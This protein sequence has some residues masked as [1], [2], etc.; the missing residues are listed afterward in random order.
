[1]HIYVD[2]FSRISLSFAY[3]YKYL[4]NKI[5]LIDTHI[6]AHIINESMYIRFAPQ[7]WCRFVLI[8]IFITTT[9]NAS[10]ISSVSQYDGGGWCGA[11]G[12][13]RLKIIGTHSIIEDVDGTFLGNNIGGFVLART[14]NV[15]QPA[16]CND[17]KKNGDETSID[18]GSK[19]GCPKCANGMEC[20]SASDCLSNVC[21]NS[22]CLVGTC[23]KFFVIYA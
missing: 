14:N 13:C 2:N 4:C 19:A 22:K 6:K 17:G 10:T 16:T 11:N 7:T 18:C 15:C 8:I 9:T 20:D 23:C 1:M 12:G 5:S 3:L 21:V